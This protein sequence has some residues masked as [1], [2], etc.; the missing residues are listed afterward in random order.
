MI[1]VLIAHHTCHGPVDPRSLLVVLLFLFLFLLLFLLL[2]GGVRRAAGL[3]TPQRLPSNAALITT[4]TAAAACVGEPDLLVLALDATLDAPVVSFDFPREPDILALSALDTPLLILGFAALVIGPLSD[5]LSTVCQRPVKDA[6][7]ALGLV[8][9]LLVVR[10]LLRRLHVLDLA[11]AL[12][13]LQAA[14]VSPGGRLIVFVSPLAFC[15][16]EGVPETTRSLVRGFLALG[17]VE[18]APP[19]GLVEHIVRRGVFHYV[20]LDHFV[21]DLVQEEHAEALGYFLGI[22]FVSLLLD[23]RLPLLL[24]VDPHR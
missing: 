1:V 4:A 9:V 5:A 7:L 16:V 19:E 2:G 24:C 11:E 13:L 23:V 15:V 20:P 14:D 12:D 10:L 6:G 17:I 8:I 22:W 3:E 21:D 18:E